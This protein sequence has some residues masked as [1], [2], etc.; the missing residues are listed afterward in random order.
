MLRAATSKPTAFFTTIVFLLAI[1]LPLKANV[2]GG[3]GVNGQ[4]AR[5]F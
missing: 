3:R 2:K 4:P 5:P 1:A